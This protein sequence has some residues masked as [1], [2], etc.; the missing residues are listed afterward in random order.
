[1]SRLFRTEF[2]NLIALFKRAILFTTTLLVL[3]IT[4]SCEPNI[5]PIIEH[6][7]G[8]RVIDTVLIP[9]LN[10][11]I[12]TSETE[13]VNIENTD[14]LTVTTMDEK[15]IILI[16]L[17]SRKIIARIDLAKSRIST[18]EIN[19]HFILN[20]YDVVNYDSIFVLYNPN[21]EIYLLDTLGVIK[22]KWTVSSE[23]EHGLAMSLYSYFNQT[24]I[25]YT[26]CSLFT[27]Q[28]SDLVNYGLDKSERERIYKTG[29]LAVVLFENDSAYVG[30]ERGRRP[31]EFLDNYYYEDNPS[32]CYDPNNNA[33]VSF[34]FSDSIF[35]VENQKQSSKLVRSSYVDSHKPFDA[36]RELDMSYIEQYFVQQTLYYRILSD[37]YRDLYYRIVIHGLPYKNDDETKNTFWD[38]PFSI[39]VTNSEFQTLGEVK[40]PAKTYDFGNIIVSEVGIGLSLNH[41]LNENLS[42]DTLTYEV[43]EVFT[44]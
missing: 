7:V 3:S 42:S 17:Q 4:T 32:I 11:K 33:I 44:E 30:D 6:Q 18:R 39:I 27:L 31:Q 28:Q 12:I 26:N 1:M 38:K 5:R 13:V 19:N 22:G 29:F 20:G 34:G 21:N 37:P 8:F 25:H 36:N 15:E 40:F 23:R 2:F 43:Y 14:V 16:N 10:S 24:N 9:V 41:E 35:V